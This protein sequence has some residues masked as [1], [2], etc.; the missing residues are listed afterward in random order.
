[1]LFMYALGLVG[2]GDCHLIIPVATRA[3]TLQCKAN[4]PY[5]ALLLNMYHMVDAAIRMYLVYAFSCYRSIPIVLSLI[6]DAMYVAVYIHI[7]YMLLVLIAYDWTPYYMT[8]DNANVHRYEF[9]IND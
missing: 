9:V 6:D 3:L 1:M 5:A 2:F 8:R 7:Y 4:S